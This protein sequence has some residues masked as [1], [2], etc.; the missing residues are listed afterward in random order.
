MTMEEN[1]P[2]LLLMA[3]TLTR[4]HPRPKIVEEKRPKDSQAVSKMMMRNTKAAMEL[5]SPSC[6]RERHEKVKA[7]ERLEQEMRMSNTME[8]RAQRQA[9]G[10]DTGSLTSAQIE[11][12][13]AEVLEWSPR[14]RRQPKLALRSDVLALIFTHGASSESVSSIRLQ[15]SPKKLFRRRLRQATVST[16]EST[17]R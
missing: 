4:I 8:E 15:L 11:Q 2:Y 14:R 9:V 7:R 3:R 5:W 13:E 6:K 12:I 1:R 10:P 16:S 17:R